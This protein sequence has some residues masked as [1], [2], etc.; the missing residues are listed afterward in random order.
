MSFN[1]ADLVPNLLLAALLLPLL[2]FVIQIFT[3]MFPGF[4]RKSKAS[5]G[6][7]VFCIGA[8]FA[9]SV[10]AFISWGTETHWAVFS[11]SEEHAEEGEAHSPDAEASAEPAEETHAKPAVFSGLWYTLGNFGDLTIGLEYYIDSLTLAMFMMVTLIATCIHVF[12][13]GYMSDELTEDHVDHEVHT[14]DGGH[15]HR[16]GRYYR[17]FAYMSLF[18]F[19]MLGIVIS[20]SILMVFIFWELVGVSSYLL[21]GFYIERKSASTAA[22]KAFIMNR[23]GDFGFLIGMM[24]IWTYFGTFSFGGLP[25]GDEA[26]T[27][28]PGL[29]TMIAD[30]HGHIDLERTEDGQAV[31]ELQTGPHAEEG[32]STA[33][34]NHSVLALSPGRRGSV[35]RLHWKKCPVPACRPGFPMRWKGR[36][37]YRPLCTPP[38]WSPPGCI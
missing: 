17:F 9:L 5:A 11:A 35:W 18:S 13:M 4:N 27:K 19:S 12:A 3:P 8:G 24:V 14:H 32:E 23:V 16:P 21:I 7:A 25:T 2:G 26:G 1:A 34:E 31:V 6:V 28:Q 20:G 15:F 37:P 29:F 22:N 33:R 10:A 30:P 36:R 38:R